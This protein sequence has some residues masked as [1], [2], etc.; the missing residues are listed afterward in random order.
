[1]ALK[2]SLVCTVRD[3]ADNITQLL[4][5]MIGQSRPA[6]EIV[7]NDCNSHD[8]TALI[9]QS[10]IDVGYPIRLVKGGYNIPSGRN[11]AIFH[12][13]GDII[14]C[15]DAGLLLDR[16]WLR[17]IIAPLSKEE[18][19]VAGGFFRPLPRSVFELALG[20][21][22]YRDA[23][24]IDGAKFL[25][26]GKSVA[27]TKF[28]WERVSGYPEWATHCE[29]VLYDLALQNAGMRFV[30]VEN[31]IVHFQPRANLRQFARQYY[32]YARGDAVAGLWPR[33]HA[34]RYAV[35]G[36]A[37]VLASLGGLAWLLLA[38][39]IGGYCLMP[40]V[41]LWRRFGE[42]VNGWQTVAAMGLVP[43]LRVV[44]DVAKMVGYVAGW[45]RLAQNPIIRREREDW[46]KA[47][48][49]VAPSHSSATGD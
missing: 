17:R 40:C 49:A 38:I 4:E 32:L 22:N 2:I 18:S 34:I 31:A 6:D 25:P 7:I 1:M 37:L 23:D 45:V 28:A 10:Y 30:F 42:G 44:G 11:N 26:F 21:T 19:D 33:R 16:H 8:D 27:F 20:N 47:H 48:L 41:R 12:A 15:T 46:M 29:D 9:V 35:Y 39:C 14:A 5:S 24:E 43:W 36:G 13:S 3:E